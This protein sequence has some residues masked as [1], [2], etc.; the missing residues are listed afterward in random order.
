[1]R[2]L[3]LRRN[4]CT[5]GQERGVMSNPVSFC[6]CLKLRLPFSVDVVYLFILR[7]HLHS[8]GL[9]TTK[10]KVVR[11]V[12]ASYCRAEQE[13]SDFSACRRFHRTRHGSR[14]FSPAA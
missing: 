14:R 9:E 1:M 7:W 11:Q 2:G 4:T 13:S 10:T 6:D 5:F 8:A 12:G 3:T